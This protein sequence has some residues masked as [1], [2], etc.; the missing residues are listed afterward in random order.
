MIELLTPAVTLS[1]FFFFVFFFFFFSGR[2][3][4]IYMCTRESWHVGDSWKL[5]PRAP[6]NTYAVVRY[7]IWDYL[8]Y[9]SI[10]FLLSFLFSLSLS[11]SLSLS[12][13][14]TQATLAGSLSSRPGAASMLAEIHA[15]RRT[16]RWMASGRWSPLSTMM[17][18][19]FYVVPA[20]P[21]LMS[22]SALHPRMR[23]RCSPTSS[24]SVV[25]VAAAAS[26][27]C[28]RFSE[29]ESTRMNEER[30]EETSSQNYH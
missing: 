5:L 10:N 13:T 24:A 16:C 2:V 17:P 3:S 27:S 19:S 7:L 14:H 8:K 4:R 26:T 21:R 25:A 23:H 29:R 22:G 28:L 15:S 6:V 9:D 1:V 12:R 20:Q 18:T 11:L 30:D